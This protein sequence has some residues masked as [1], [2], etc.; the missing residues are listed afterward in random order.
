MVEPKLIC[1]LY[2]LTH[3]DVYLYV[4]GICTHNVLYIYE[5]G[6]KPDMI[7]H[8]LTFLHFLSLNRL[9]PYIL[10]PTWGLRFKGQTLV[11]EIVLLRFHNVF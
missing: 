10:A 3:Y 2:P 1:V 8:Y 6:N 4:I 5:F 7:S 9:I 11:Y